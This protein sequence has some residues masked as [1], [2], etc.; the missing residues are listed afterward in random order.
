MPRATLSGSMSLLSSGMFL[1]ALILFA[2]PDASGY[3][4]G[5]PNGRTGAP[6]E[7]T[8]HDCHSSFALNSG[9]GAFIINGPLFFDADQTYVITVTLE[10][11]DQTRWG[12][13]LT[14]LDV[15][16]ITI[17]DPDHTQLGTAGGNSYVK[18]TGAGTYPGT[19]GPT[20]WTFEWTA[21]SDPPTSVTF[22]AAG[23]AANNNGGTSG[24][25]I[26]TAAHTATLMPQDGGDWPTA[27]LRLG[28][29]IDPNPVV[30]H[31]HLVLAL[32]ESGR[33]NLTIFDASGRIVRKLI[34][35][36]LDGGLHR[37]GWDGR[38]SDGH[39][40]PGGVYLCRLSSG[41]RSAVQRLV[42]F[43]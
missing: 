26:Y 37:F 13:E 25:Y 22:Y 9:D 1:L 16:T 43:D 14:P 39:Y 12:F 40:L 32:P 4:G 34:D 27:Q 19:A 28:L 18:Q 10:D 2:A 17:T 21:P 30:N 33:T 6:G 31:T 41:G 15:G 38:D 42:K 23:N 36:D 24:D 7:G 3:S 29:S 11:P 8:C 20:S 35:R 5:P